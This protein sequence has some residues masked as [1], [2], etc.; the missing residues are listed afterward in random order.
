MYRSYETVCR[1]AMPMSLDIRQNAKKTPLPMQVMRIYTMPSYTN[2]KK[3]NARVSPIAPRFE[4]RSACVSHLFLV[5]FL[6][7]Q[8]AMSLRDRHI[9]QAQTPLRLF[10]ARTVGSRLPLSLHR[11]LQGPQSF[12]GGP[13]CLVD[14]ALLHSL[15]D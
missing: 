13:N 14:L 5:T 7:C 2:C 1:T 15:R 4:F 6:D 8:L 10:L 9:F 3:H 12:F 11:A